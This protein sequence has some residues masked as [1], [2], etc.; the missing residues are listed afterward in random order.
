VKLD[1][2]ATFPANNLNHWDIGTHLGIAYRLSNRM[3]AMMSYEHGFKN[4]FKDL[5]LQAYDRK[6]TLGLSYRFGR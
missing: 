6:W 1:P 2:G 4:L 5:D 3:E